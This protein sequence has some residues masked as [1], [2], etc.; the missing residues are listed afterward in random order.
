MFVCVKKN[1]TDHLGYH[2]VATYDN[3]LG[4]SVPINSRHFFE[5]SHHYHHNISNNKNNEDGRDD[6]DPGKFQ[7]RPTSNPYGQPPLLYNYPRAQ[8]DHENNEDS[9]ESTVTPSAMIIGLENLIIFCHFDD[10]DEDV[11]VYM[12]HDDVEGEEARKE[13]TQKFGNYLLDLVNADIRRRKTD[14]VMQGNYTQQVMAIEDQPTINSH[15]DHTQPPATFSPN[16]RPLQTPFDQDQDLGE[17]NLS[18]LL[19]TMLE[20]Q[21]DMNPTQS[22]PDLQ[23]SIAEL[24]DTKPTISVQTTTDETPEQWTI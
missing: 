1:I 13:A 17:L 19:S 12:S 14:A 6:R 7:M 21:S 9:A 15:F 2:F 20:H 11:F 23:Q 24:N 3:G 18:H 16:I 8:S 4:H 5:Q 10:N 22:L